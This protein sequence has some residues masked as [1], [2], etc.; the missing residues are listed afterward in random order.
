MTSTK[1]S[2]FCHI[3]KGDNN[4][5]HFMNWESEIISTLLCEWQRVKIFISHF[6]SE[7]Q[8]NSDKENISVMT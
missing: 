4:A 6:T 3:T 8:T 2:P 7:L 5:S 1:L